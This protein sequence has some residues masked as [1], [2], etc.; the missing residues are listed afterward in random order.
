MLSNPDGL[1]AT[2]DEDLLLWLILKTSN[3]LLLTLLLA[4]LWLA[5]YAYNINGNRLIISWSSPYLCYDS[6][7]I[8]YIPI[9]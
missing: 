4:S 6:S 9:M 3:A 7:T 2:S 1:F 5:L 8:Y